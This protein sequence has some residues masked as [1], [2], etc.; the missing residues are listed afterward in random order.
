MGGSEA[1]LP[2]DIGIGLMGLGGVGG[3]VAQVLSSKAQTLCSTA[4]SS[5]SLRRVLVRDPGKSRSFNPPSQ[6]LTTSPDDI[7]DDP[8]IHIVIEVIGGESPAHEYISKALTRGK[9]VV[10]A[11]K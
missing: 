9:H 3:G 4:G 8:D 11:N 2:R 10:T 7:L 6:L 1:T 5:L